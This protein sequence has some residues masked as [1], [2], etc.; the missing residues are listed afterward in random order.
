MVERMT[1]ILDAFEGAG[2]R[3]T[4]EEVACRTGLPRSTVH[5]IL[6]QMVR[7]EWVDHASFGYCL[8]RRAKSLGAGDNGQSRIREAAAPLLHELNMHTGMVAHLAV[9]D[10][11]E[12]LYLDKVG[13]QLAATLTSRVGGR[14]PAYATACGKAILAALAPE[15]VDALYGRHLPRRTDRTIADLSTLHQELGRIRRRH[16]LAFEDGEAMGGIACV[17]APVR[18]PEGPVAGISLC[19]PA[20][21]G[22]LER[23]APLVADVA[24]DVSRMLH[25]ELGTPRRARRTADVPARSWSPHT[26]ERLVATQSGQWI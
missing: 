6:D 17:G 21:P 18:S 5:R 15:Q 22:H 19:G 24:R 16:G 20:R 9:L 23:I 10:R 25:P 13:G 7:L 26:M 12:C 14:A 3:L 1:L 2:S 4:L 8:G 11:G